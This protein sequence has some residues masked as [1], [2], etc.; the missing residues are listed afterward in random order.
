[1]IVTGQCNT[2]VEL[3]F[4]AEMQYADI[5]NEVEVDVLVTG[6]DGQ[7]LTIPTF[8]A[9]Q[10]V[11]K[12]RFV[13]HEP[14]R[15][16][17]TTRCN[18][19]TDTGLQN[20][21]GLIEI[22]PYQGTNTLY[23][24]GRL[25]KAANQRTLEHTDG[26]PFFWLGD[27]WWMG[28]STRLDWPIGFHHLLADRAQKGFSLLQIVAGPYPDFLPSAT[29][30]PGQA[31]EAG[32][33]WEAEW[34]RI[35]PAY[36]DL[37]D[38]KIAE[39]VNYGLVPC[40]V[41]MW[42]YYLPVMGL[43]RVKKHW[44]YLVARYACYPSVLCLAG[45]ANMPAYDHM[46]DAELSAK[47]RKEQMEGWTEVARYV[48][49]LDP[50]HNPIG[51]H[52]SYPN[53]RS[54]LLDDTLL[55]VDMLQTGHSGYL[56]LPPTMEAVTS[57][58]AIAPRMPVVNSEVCYEGIMGGSLEDVQRFLFWSSIT[59]GSAGHTYGAQGIWAMNSRY[60]EFKGSTG[61]WGGAFWEDVMYYP[62]S[63]QVGIGRR[64]FERYPWAE[65]QLLERS[66][67]PNG[68]KYRYGLG[69]PSEIEIYYL[70]MGC[71]QEELQ[72]M[73]VNIWGESAGL[74]LDS[75]DYH[76]FYFNP[77]DA[78]EVE[79]GQFTV[80]SEGKWFP[81]KKPSMEDWVLV[82]ERT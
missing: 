63:T 79:L 35:N 70:P 19:A 36:F 3:S 2:P 21:T 44:R 15:Y 61:S 26:T 24:H 60:Q 73:Q 20:V 71:V 9:G 41:G 53:G 16:R 51:V 82:V 1:M 28:L 58:N 68:R 17:Y 56:S 11:F 64:F 13:A 47:D 7:T 81:S 25:Q 66:E 45:E 12:A 50:Y 48:R 22:A 46:A 49:A 77:R 18:V 38:S 34:A 4:V 69:I 10:G 78:S 27:T 6:S 80:G 72:G 59:S 42:G 29:W 52:P 30:D 54:M 74:T 8:W 23:Q 39:I 43:E 37:A 76:A 75:G 57:C 67:L 65:F 62:G 14:G 55:D 33:P 40:L 5:F 32:W 31:N